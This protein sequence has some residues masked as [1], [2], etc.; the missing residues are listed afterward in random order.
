M[1][2]NDAVIYMYQCWMSQKY[3]C[4]TFERKQVVSEHSYRVWK[5]CFVNEI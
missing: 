3:N 5:L 2:S 1:Y 4:K